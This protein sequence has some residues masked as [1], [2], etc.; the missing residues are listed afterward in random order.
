M[1]TPAAFG[2]LMAGVMALPTG[3][4]FALT[5]RTDDSAATG[6]QPIL[7]ARG[8]GGGGRGGGGRGGGGGG[9]GRH[10]GGGRSGFKGNNNRASLDRGSRRPSGG[11]SQGG[12]VG[13][14]PGPSLDRP[15]GRPASGMNRP[16][17]QRPAAGG[18]QRPGGN[19]PEG[20]WSRPDGVT[21]RP[22][23]PEGGWSRPD[24]VPNR[25]NRPEG[26]W[27]RPD[28]V[29]NRP[30]RPDT[31]NR[32]D[33]NWNR[34]NNGKNWNRPNN[35]NN[36]N[37]PINVGSLNLYPGWARPGW[38]YARPWNYGWYGGWA[39]PSWGWWGASA[40]TW[41]ITSLA[42]A[43]IINSAVDDAVSSQKTYIVVPNSN[44]QLLY[45]TVQP[46]EAT[47][48]SFAVQQDAST[49]Q[50]SADCRAGLLN[51]NQPQDAK[52]AEL[53]NAACQVAYGNVTQ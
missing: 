10:G 28:G 46:T 47:G 34:P 25:P 42:T 37:R 48:V 32:P 18:L 14:R 35:W 50:W 53:L 33:G 30:N 29:T 43:A 9:G 2:L 22:N 24:G 26:G 7:L 20:G 27:S 16:G 39:T 11:W 36:W 45:G 19:R 52:E 4:G 38:G 17:G 21:N 5:L 51:G 12:R 49:Y 31:W 23:R 15:M 40:L 44:Y 13:T 3:P 8:G 41:G 6:T 1:K